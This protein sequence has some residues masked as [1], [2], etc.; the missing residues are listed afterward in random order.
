[1]KCFAYNGITVSLAWTWNDGKSSTLSR[2]LL[3]SSTSYLWE[4]IVSLPLE[5]FQTTFSHTL[6]GCGWQH[7]KGGN[8]FRYFCSHSCPPLYRVNCSKISLNNDILFHLSTRWIL[9]GLFNGLYLTRHARMLCL[10][11]QSDHR[12][13]N[14]WNYW[15]FL[16]TLYCLLRPWGT[17]FLKV[18]IACR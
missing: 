1:M 11:W 7:L 12:Q 9:F 8:G 17:C 10:H 15:P 14:L 16:F 18:H 3:I 6:L 5:R 13:K 4:A 2:F